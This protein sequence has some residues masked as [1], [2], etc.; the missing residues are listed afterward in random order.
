MCLS[1]MS[2]SSNSESVIPTDLKT[3]L[4]QVRMKGTLEYIDGVFKSLLEREAV[5]NNTLMQLQQMLETEGKQDNELRN[6]KKD[7]QGR[8]SSDIVAKVYLDTLVKFKHDTELAS[9]ANNKL[10]AM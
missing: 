6:Q 2:D 7:I 3:R 5:N 1:F 10:K 4:N 9:N 8:V